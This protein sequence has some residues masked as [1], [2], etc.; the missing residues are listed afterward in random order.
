MDTKIKI[1]SKKDVKVAAELLASGGNVV[2]PTETVYGLCASSL[3]KKAIK[4]IYKIKRRP[5]NKPLTLHVSSRD[6]IYGLA[7]VNDISEKLIKEFL[8]GP[9]TIVLPRRDEVSGGAFAVSKFVGVRL[10]SN[11]VFNE[12]IRELGCPI[13]ATSVNISGFESAKTFDKV[14]EIKDLDVAAILNGGN[15]ELGVDS[16]VVCVGRDKRIKI[17]RRGA[18]SKEE[19]YHVLNLTGAEKN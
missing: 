11:C 12:V 16:T 18:I 13:V 8:P 5:T 4:K 7:Y 14:L 17:L 19:I 1:L 6:A 15:C 2:L 9:L 3:I 10:S